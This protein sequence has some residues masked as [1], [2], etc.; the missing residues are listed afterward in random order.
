MNEA[1]APVPQIPSEATAAGI[2]F[3]GG[4]SDFR[5]LITRGAL[6][7]LVTLTLYRFW[8]A[9]DMRRH[10]WSHTSVGGNALEYTGTAKEL[11]IGFLFA[12][13]ILVPVYLVYFFIGL[14]AEHLQAFASIP[15]FIFFYLFFQFAI[16]RA[17]R[18]RLTR[19]VWRGVRFWMTG[20]GWSYAWRA[21][22][23]TLLAIVTLGLALP[24]Q[25][26]VLERYKMR[27]S[28][29][30]DLPG[31]F[32]G[33]GAD[34][35][36]RCWWLWLAAI[37]ILVV[38][39]ALAAVSPVAALILFVPALVG[40]PCVYAA[41]KAIGWR[42][43]VSGI[44]FGDVSFESK[45]STGALLGVYWKVIVWGVLLLVALAAWMAGV[46]GLVFAN[47][48]AS[49]LTEEH[50]AATLQSP[51]VLIMMILGYLA[52]AVVFGL[53]MRLYLARDVWERVASSTIVHNLSAAENVAA[54]GEAAGALGEG[55]ADG[56][57]VGGF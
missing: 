15:L 56:L 51:P 47:S 32:V 20:S 17:R 30:G 35:F 39:G 41:Y 43:W 37:L 4:R 57:D 21:V 9:T 1:P 8:L 24:W 6:L 22:L 19:T 45:L 5:R 14:E 18:Y 34:L 12:I 25:Q 23:W 2:T 3:S 54:R 42:W 46:V 40:F 50:M 53:V 49:G 29:Y 11:L 33:T 48:R 7:E 27:H 36:K 31:R 28:H 38:L 52:A 55:L 44:R 26:A 16:Y 10:L 13:A